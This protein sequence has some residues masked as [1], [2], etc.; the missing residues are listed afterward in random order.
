MYKKRTWRILLIYLKLLGQAGLACCA[1][2][3]WTQGQ[4]KMLALVFIM[5]CVDQGES[6][7]PSEAANLDHTQKQNDPKWKPSAEERNEEQYK[8]TYSQA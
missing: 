2:L 5:V 3:K 7:L 8:A 1:V 4:G 6:S